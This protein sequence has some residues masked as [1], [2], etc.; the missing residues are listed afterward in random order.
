MLNQCNVPCVDCAI[1]GGGFGCDVAAI[2]LHCQQT[3][4]TIRNLVVIEG[5]QE[6]KHLFTATMASPSLSLGV[7]RLQWNNVM[8][9]SENFV[10]T[11]R[12]VQIVVTSFVSLY[13]YVAASCVVD[14]VRSGTIFIHGHSYV[15]SDWSTFMNDSV[16][17]FRDTIIA[18]CKGN[19][20]GVWRICTPENLRAA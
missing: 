18:E 13:E 5:V 9:S 7:G 17:D 12:R 11:L 3:Q 8:L 10:S 2:G 14:L 1:I 15:P 19:C 4:Q 6:L 20:N 16:I